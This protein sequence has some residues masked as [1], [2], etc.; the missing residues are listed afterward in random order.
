MDDHKAGFQRPVTKQGAYSS[1]EKHVESHYPNINDAPH[2]AKL[3]GSELV[4]F[5][6]GGGGGIS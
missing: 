6:Q 4:L 5:I 1:N 3:K 2:P